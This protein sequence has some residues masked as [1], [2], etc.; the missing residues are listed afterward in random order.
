MKSSALMLLIGALVAA[1][2]Q[3]A[4]KMEPIKYKVGDVECQGFLAYD[5][6]AT[7]KRPG[8]LVA[9]EWWGLTEYPKHR[10]EQLAALGY[11]AFAMDTYGDGK[12]TDDP[13]QAGK[14]AGALKGNIDELRAR[15]NAA[16]DV[17][18]SQ[19]NV[20]PDKLAAIG[21]C[22]GGTTVLEL[23]RSGAP[24]RGVVS[25]HGGLGTPHPEDAKNIKGSVLICHGGDDKFESPEEIAAFQQSMRDAKVDW[26]M[27]IYGGAVHAFTNP[28]ADKHGI[29]GI[30]YNANADKR[31]WQ[32]MKEFFEE[33]F[34]K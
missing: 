12:T 28:E 20:D 16:L 32:A 10:A 1:S 31:S 34:A 2:A 23:A 9:P 26:V 3:G 21:Y 13:K 5:T 14:W 7:G 6:D 22:F 25:F 18:K 8:V 19:P 4:I 29:P 30:G 24:L 11:V 33:I 15:A 27:N 17:L